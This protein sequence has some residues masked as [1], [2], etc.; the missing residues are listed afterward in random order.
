MKYYSI[1][2][3]TL[4]LVQSSSFIPSSNTKGF[5]FNQLDNLL[6][7]MGSNAGDGEDEEHRIPSSITGLGRQPSG[8]IR[9]GP[10][11]FSPVDRLRGPDRF[12]GLQRDSDNLGE[13]LQG[14]QQQQR[15]LM[16]TDMG[17]VNKYGCWC[18]FEDDHGRGKGEPQDEIDTICRTLHHGYECIIKDQEEKGTPCVPWKIPYVTAFGGG[19]N[20]FSGVNIQ[21]LNSECEAVNTP[22]SCEAQT[23]KV[24]GYFVQSYFIYAIFGGG[25]DRSMRHEEGFDFDS[26]CNINYSYGRKN[27]ISSALGYLDNINDIDD[28]R[29]SRPFRFDSSPMQE[30]CCGEYPIR[31]PYRHKGEKECCRQ[32]VYNSELFYCCEDGTV[33]FACL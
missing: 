24:E 23:C 16:Q 5:R 7:S 33:Q 27:F 1:F 6:K 17:L 29:Y 13:S 30:N 25:I 11:G 14:L 21:N 26:V 4:G 8:V 3:L 28:L 31:Y 32:T 18:F 9:P 22:G 19:F 2:T 15:A 20:P 12:P 10:P